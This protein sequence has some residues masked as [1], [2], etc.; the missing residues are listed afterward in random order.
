MSQTATAPEVEQLVHNNMK[1]VPWMA[2]RIGNAYIRNR[3]GSFE[4]VMGWGYVG[5]VLAAQ[6]FDPGRN[7][8]FSTYAAQCIRNEIFRN[9]TR[10]GL[11]A[12]TSY[13]VGAV[14]SGGKFADTKLQESAKRASRVKPLE[15]YLGL[16]P[17]KQSDPDEDRE[18][19][20]RA[21]QIISKPWRK[22]LC[23]YYGIDTIPTTL[24]EIARW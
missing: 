13:A 24:G 21:L 7:I 2:K 8:K 3:L 18:E 20:H 6:N 16:T 10:S 15:H 1:L 9:L 22:L 12:V 11:I 14:C 19:L 23:S 4:D 5:L 17:A